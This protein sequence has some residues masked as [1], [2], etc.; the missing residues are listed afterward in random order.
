MIV[1][2]YALGVLAAVANA[3][4]NV[5]QRA[6][7]RDEPVDLEFSM[8]LI[9]HLVRKP[10]WLAGIGMMTSS[11]LLQAA[12]LG[13]GTLAAVE[14]LLVLELPLTLV[15]SAIWLGG[16]LGRREWLAVVG[17]TLGTI[18]LI[19][20]LGPSGGRSR[21]P[22]FVW[23][24]AIV[25]TSA[26]AATVFLIARRQPDRGRRAMLLGVCT[27][28]ADGLA[29]SLM[30]GMTQHFSHG[31]L[32]GVL[33]AWQLYGAIAAGVAAVWLRQNAD[34]AGRL[35]AAQPG[36]TLADPYVSI[37]WG[38]TVF[39]ESFRSG[40]WIALAILAGAVMSVSAVALARAPALH[41]ERAAQEEGHRRPEGADARGSSE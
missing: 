14:P 12:G 20:F 35:V 21:I 26:L 29:A 9:A 3:G 15:A 4:S 30:K 19:A 17:M 40:F 8:R 32:L 38:A 5:L 25:A 33:T 22:A 13:F 39:G 31:G 23:L 1:L 6:A 41:G 2:A 27:G 36:M 7:N 18:G 16:A 10:V 11:F 34:N 28:T 24:M 37:I